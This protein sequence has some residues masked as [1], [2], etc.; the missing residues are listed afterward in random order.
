MG[1]TLSPQKGHSPPIFSPCLL[2]PNGWMDQHTT[3]YGGRPRPRPHC[4]RSGTSCP[5]KKGHSSLHPSTVFGPCLSW[6]N[7]QTAGWIKMPLGMEVGLN[8]GHIV[9]DG[10]PAT[11]QRGRAPIFGPCVLWP[12]SWMDQDATWYG[13]KPQ[14]RPHCV[15]WGPS[16]PTRKGHS[17]PL[18]P[19]YD[20]CLFWPNGRA[21]QLLLSTCLNIWFLKLTFN[22]MHCENKFM[23]TR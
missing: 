6:P 9:L 20:P 21:S 19:L 23:A 18:N 4:V 14:P 17:S 15:R 1:T 10:D 7:G 3:W 8:P 2:Q 13:C 11:P 16:C 5:S 22:C 12:N